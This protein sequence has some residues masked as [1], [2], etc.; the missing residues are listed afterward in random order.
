MAEKYRYI[1]TVV[2]ETDRKVTTRALR[3]QVSWR[4]EGLLGTTIDDAAEGV[5]TKARVGQLT[6]NDPTGLGRNVSDRWLSQQ[7][8]ADAD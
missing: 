1:A 4:L 6:S 7:D 2:I 8:K 3:E 5:I